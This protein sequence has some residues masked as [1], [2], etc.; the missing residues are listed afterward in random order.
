[1]GKHCYEIL[2]RL[3]DSDSKTT[4]EEKLTALEQY[5]I[6]KRNV[7]YE[8]FV[9]NNCHQGPRETVDEGS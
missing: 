1:M 8:T 3:P 5:F 6:P 4:V 9:F 2:Q 7:T